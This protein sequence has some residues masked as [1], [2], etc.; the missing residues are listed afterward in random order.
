MNHRDATA[1]DVAVLA[2]AVAFSLIPTARAQAVRTTGPVSA[3]KEPAAGSQIVL[4]VPPG[5]ELP[6]EWDKAI[7]F[8]LFQEEID[9]GLEAPL[10]ISFREDRTKIWALLPSNQ[11][12]GRTWLR[13]RL[14]D[15]KK[16]W[17]PLSNLEMSPGSDLELSR[18][19]PVRVPLRPEEVPRLR[20]AAP[21]RVHDYILRHNR[22]VANVRLLFIIAPNGQILSVGL[23]QPSRVGKLDTL[24][25]AAARDFKF[26]PASPELQPALVLL[27]LHFEFS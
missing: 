12:D 17:V 7:W 1:L 16:A 2:L 15:K 26:E 6:L 9:L 5:T 25:A 20:E 8:N 4:Q 27:V 22:A 18:P 3:H 19:V 23:V 11:K 10:F 13:V 24:V 14:P 21:F